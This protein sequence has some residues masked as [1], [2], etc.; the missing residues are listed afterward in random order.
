MEK[1]E[2]KQVIKLLDKI[3]AS[4]NVEIK[5]AFR[6]LLIVATLT[7][8]PAEGQGPLESL[9]FSEL[10]M[11]KKQLTAIQGDMART[12]EWARR[13]GKS[14]YDDYYTRQSSASRGYVDPWAGAIANDKTAHQMS[15]ID[16]NEIFKSRISTTKKV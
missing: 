2:L 1:T 10:D 12:H 4:N 16:W 14:Y 6:E 13:N 9:V 3:I 15:E 7:E 8:A 5:D 11:L